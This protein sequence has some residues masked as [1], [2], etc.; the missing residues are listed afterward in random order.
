MVI[1]G[2]GAS[3]DQSFLSTSPVGM[4]AIGRAHREAWLEPMG[5][6]KRQV[7]SETEFGCAASTVI[8]FETANDS[9]RP[10]RATHSRSYE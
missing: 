8:G 7:S 9:C 10:T 1:L 6:S 2:A 3:V 4:A 5:K